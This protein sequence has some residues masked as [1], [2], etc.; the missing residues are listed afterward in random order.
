MHYNALH[1]SLRTFSLNK[2]W[3][4]HFLI[5]NG[6]CSHS[7]SCSPKHFTRVSIIETRYMFSICYL[8]NDLSTT[9]A[10]FVCVKT[11][12]LWGKIHLQ[13]IFLSASLEVYI[14]SLIEKSC[15]LLGFT[16]P[17]IPIKL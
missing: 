2:N 5:K 12:K 3:E 9:N 14:R 4:S 10:L 6:L 7:I 11:I 13:H 16:F 8:V 15:I 1:T 17:S